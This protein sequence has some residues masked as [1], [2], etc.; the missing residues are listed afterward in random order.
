M[1][2]KKVPY[3][4]F[5]KNLGKNIP[6]GISY[7]EYRRSAVIPE[8]IICDYCDTVR[9]DIEENSCP[10][11][12]A[13]DIVVLV[14]DIEIPT[15][16]GFMDDIYIPRSVRGAVELNPIL[17]ASQGVGYEETH[18][19]TLGRVLIVVALAVVVGIILRGGIH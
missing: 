14:P 11:C 10:K 16:L 1:K 17:E 7:L 18:W 3:W 12:G 5:M 8:N 13:H 6:P 4:E 9:K 19:E 15:D 2:F